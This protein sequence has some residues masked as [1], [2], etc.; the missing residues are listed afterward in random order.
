MGKT[1]HCSLCKHPKVLALNNAIKANK[2]YTVA[3][4]EM[5]DEYGWTFAKRTFL[6]HK[7]HITAPLLTAA[8][9]ARKEAAHQPQNNR[10]VLEAIRDI[11]MRKALE[12]PEEVKI[13]HALRAAKILQDA[14]G[15]QETVMV[16]MAKAV[17]QGYVPPTIEGEYTEV[18]QL[19]VSNEPV[20]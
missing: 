7:N 16:V 13:D 20:S 14:E 9:A 19:E 5:A 1:G 8:E 2:G 12:N 3:L 15:K 6:N 18:P 4:R 11:G 10:A 17:M